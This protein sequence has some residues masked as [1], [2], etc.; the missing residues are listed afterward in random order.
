MNDY[1]DFM[2]KYTSSDNPAGLM[3]DYTEIVS[4]YAD[5]GKKIDDIDEDSLSK[6]DYD[7]Y[8]DVTARVTKKL[9][10]VAE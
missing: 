7:Y 3:K 10:E 8:I 6:A 1:V 5:W 9:A 2:K 4:K